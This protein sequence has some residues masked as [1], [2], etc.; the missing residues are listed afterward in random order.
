MKKLINNNVGKCIID[1]YW[2]M[3][4]IFYM[5]HLVYFFLN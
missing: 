1:T 4:I 2:H 5:D 3:D